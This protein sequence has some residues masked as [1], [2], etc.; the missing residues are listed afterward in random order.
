M[1]HAK[2]ARHASRCAN[3]TSTQPHHC[4]TRHNSC[5]MARPNRRVAAATARESHARAPHAQTS[6]WSAHGTRER[7]VR[8]LPRRRRVD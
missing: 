7:A 4:A 3:E 2:N 6:S 8:G 5:A 1:G